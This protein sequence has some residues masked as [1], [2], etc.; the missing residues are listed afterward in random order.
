MAWILLSSSIQ[1]EVGNSNRGG[2]N[3]EGWSGEGN[4]R[5]VQEGGDIHIYLWVIHIDV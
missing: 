5:E 1:A 4:G 3:L 2:I